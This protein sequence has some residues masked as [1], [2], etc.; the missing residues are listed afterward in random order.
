M[1]VLRESFANI[2][3][4]RV[5]GDVVKENHHTVWMNFYPPKEWI[6]KARDFNIVLKPM[7]HI[8]RHIKK[9]NVNRFA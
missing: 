5:K 8:K 2:G 1:I 6:E 9:H 7:L 3:E 4:R